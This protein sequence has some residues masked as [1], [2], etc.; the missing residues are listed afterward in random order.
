VK[1]AALIDKHLKRF[2]KKRREVKERVAEE[3]KELNVEPDDK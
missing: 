2:V 3:V 1:S